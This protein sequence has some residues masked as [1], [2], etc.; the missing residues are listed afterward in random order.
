MSVDFENNRK[1]FFAAVARCRRGKMNDVWKVKNA[2]EEVVEGKEAVLEQWRGYFEELLNEGGEDGLE[3]ESDRE[4][5]RKVGRRVKLFSGIVR[6]R[7][8]GKRAG[9]VKGEEVKRALGRLK[10]GKA[11][12]VCGLVNELLVFGGES[13]V[14]S[15]RLLFS[16]CWKAGQVP[17]EWREG[18][19]VPI[20]KKGDPLECSN[21]RGI[22]LLSVVGKVFASVLRERVTR[23]VGLQVEQAGFQEGRSCMEQVWVLQRV[24]EERARQGQ[25]TF[26]HLLMYRKRMT[27]SGGRGC[28]R[29][30]GQ[31]G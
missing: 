5:R 16:R 28:G 31:L 20:Y 22:T 4:W 8:M 13:M 11:G 24:L 27:E 15:L 6:R 2:E 21:Y 9:K 25:K 18:M 17:R 29:G 1:L 7:R 14:E 12:G 10:S 30:F 3:T 23:I 26:C 19:V